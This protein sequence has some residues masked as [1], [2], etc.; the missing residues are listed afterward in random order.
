MANLLEPTADGRPSPQQWD[1]APPEWSIKD[2]TLRV[3]G[4]GPGLVKVPVELHAPYHYQAV[5]MLRVAAGQRGAAWVLRAKD[6]QHYY[7]F[8]LSLPSQSSPEAQLKGFVYE[9]GETKP[10]TSITPTLLNYHPLDD[11]DLLTVAVEAK[12]Y[13]FKH[14]ITLTLINDT[15]ENPNLPF[16]SIERIVTF[17][18]GDNRYEYGSMGLRAAGENDEM[19]VEHIEI[20]AFE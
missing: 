16:D 4:A 20:T 2:R 5:L 10:L 1:S 14:T 19:L 17:I 7:L 3:R 18:D 12:N 15:P 11:G 13:E 6:R 9:D 8:E